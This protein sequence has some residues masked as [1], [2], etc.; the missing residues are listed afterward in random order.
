MQQIFIII[1]R[2]FI[3]RTRK[4]SFILFS[5]I[6]PLF[7]LL[8]SIFILIH[9]YSSIERKS[10]GI[11]DEQNRIASNIVGN[12]S[13]VTYNTLP[14]SL[15]SARNKLLV[16][17]SNYLGI[18]YISNNYYTDKLT[19]IK[20]YV[21][22]G[23]EMESSTIKMVQNH[24]SNKLLYLKLEDLKINEDEISNIKL[25]KFSIILPSGKNEALKKASSSLAYFIGLLL[26]VMYIMYNNA[27]LSGIMEEKGS[28]IVE[29]LSLIVDPFF[30][31]IGK[32]V[33]IGI[34]AFIQMITWIIVFIFYSKC[35]NY[36]STEIL[37]L[38]GSGD[39][40]FANILSISELFPMWKIY[41]FVPIFFLMGFLFNG[42]VTAIVG[43]TSN[44]GN[45]S[46]LTFLSSFVNIASIYIAMYAAGTPDTLLS[47]ISI[48]IPFLS[49]ILVPTLLP[50]DIPLLNILLSL[51]I[52]VVSFIAI[53]FVAGRVY[54]ISMLTYGTKISFRMILKLLTKKSF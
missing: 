44:P 36:F 21:N 5:L 35:L 37:H 17:K 51:L 48:F 1:K 52:L 29:V 7:L 30:L 49:P 24:I 50:Y 41:V 39:S 20:F 14:I 42:S 16:D 3:T 27:L 19:P 10:I 22:A 12:Y 31:M 13:G 8:P 38:S 53:T 45:N 32:I 11:I 4:K 46:P 54:K 47:R 40:G 2:E 28:R 26:Y 43:A 33:G 23:S 34:V 25:N 18:I 9:Q 15:D 6:S